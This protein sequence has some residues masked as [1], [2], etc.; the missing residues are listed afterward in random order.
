MPLVSASEAEQSTPRHAPVQVAADA[1]ASLLTTVT[2]LEDIAVE[3]NALALA[4]GSP[5]TT[6]AWLSSWWEAYGRGSLTVVILRD[7]DGRLMAGLPC[8]R[9]SRS[10]WA[11][12]ANLESGRWG[13]V[14]SS[15]RAERLVWRA[16]TRFGVA[17]L[18]LEGLL[19]DDDATA[20]AHAE[21]TGAGYRVVR[22]RGPSSPYLAL[23]STP[24][25]LLASLSRGMRKQLRRSR[26]ELGARGELRFRVVRSRPDLGTALDQVL[27][28]EG[29]GWK[30]RAGT[31]ILSNPALEEL[32]RGFAVRAADRGW[33]RLYLLELDGQP[34]AAAFGC[35]FGNVGHLMKAGFDESLAVHSPGTLLLWET[36][37]ACIDEGLSGCDLL[38]GA[39][40]YKLRW[41]D[42]VRPRVGLR[43]Y[44]GARTFP[45]ALYW[46]NGRPALR[47]VARHTIRRISSDSHLHAVR[48]ALPSARYLAAIS[49]GL[50]RW[51]A[52]SRADRVAPGDDD[53]A[54]RTAAAS[55]SESPGGN[56]R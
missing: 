45:E 56:V 38:G 14:A 28:L 29:S 15:A 54:S 35:V 3:W 31:A 21:L 26:R 6:V 19:E 24:D 2:E 10:I 16:V 22:T 43:A 40:R 52:T 18:R 1:Y 12:T 49:G 53:T 50:N 32:Y 25:A 30:A 20:V 4:G 7:Q 48:G 23:P 47:W 51:A 8:R 39:D 42:T 44:R 5:F 36:L 41:T 33:L 27:R 46:R 34:I 37:Q 13:A 11:A 9:V 55:A 17:G